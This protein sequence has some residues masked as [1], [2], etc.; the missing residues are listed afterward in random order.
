MRAVRPESAASSPGFCRVIAQRKMRPRNLLK[1][2]Y[3]GIIHRRTAERA[4]NWHSLRRKFLRDNDAETV[5]DLRYEP[6]QYRSSS[7][8]LPAIW[9]RRAASA[10]CSSAATTVR[11]ACTLHIALRLGAATL[12]GNRAWA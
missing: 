4:D 6:H 7:I 11:N 1:M 8:G 12:V 5:C 10:G 3:E 2:V 9:A